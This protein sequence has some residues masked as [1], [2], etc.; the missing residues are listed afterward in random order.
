MGKAEYYS[1]KNILKV[2][3]PY[4]MIIGERSNGKTF[5]VVRYAID[6]YLDK[7]L[8][9][10]Y[11]RRLKDSFTGRKLA[12]LFRPHQSYI[13]QRTDG[14][15]NDVYYY[16]REFYFCKRNEKGEIEYKAPL[17]FGYGCA[18]STWETDK[19]ADLA[20]F[21]V[22]LFDEF[23]S[24]TIYLKNEFIKFQ[25]CISSLVRDRTDAKIFML[26]N[27]V[28]KD[29]PYFAE[30]GINIY[31]AK[32]GNIYSFSYKNNPDVVTL[33]MEYCSTIADTKKDV[34]KMYFAFDNTKLDMI[35]SGA[36]ETA[37][38]P[39]E[40]EYMSDNADVLTAI[41]FQN[42]NVS[43]CAYLKIYNDMLYIYY[44]Q[45]T[46]DFVKD[47][48]VITLDHNI[49]PMYYNSLNYNIDLFKIYKELM[50]NN[51]EYYS[52]NECGEMMRNIKIKILGFRNDE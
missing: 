1:L 51:K 4:N 22:I 23:L 38:Y 37:S 3:A 42:D 40:P 31:K 27:T 48:F 9:F 14:E 44:R 43:I 20:D 17:P 7:G 41:Y 5:S 24:R 34:N 46:K 21:G 8:C 32:Q 25:D 50:I 16:S 11:M 19:G 10:A 39:H 36:W 49:S 29:C 45:N 47:R 35:K 30:F 33:A 15:Y 13:S 6:T 12:K 18:L 52:N 28:N 2:N 26:G